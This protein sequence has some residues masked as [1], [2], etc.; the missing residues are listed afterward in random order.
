MA[1]L[2][3]P[4]QALL[5]GRGPR[6]GRDGG[7]G[8]GKPV[9]AHRE[10]CTM[11]VRP[12]WGAGFCIGLFGALCQVA[13][14]GSE[15]GWVALGALDWKARPSPPPRPLHS[16]AAML[17]PGAWSF[18]GDMAAPR[19][20]RLTTDRPN[21]CIPHAATTQQEPST[22]DEEEAE[23]RL[24]EDEDLFSLGCG[25]GVGPEEDG[26]YGGAVSSEESE[27]EEDSDADGP[28]GDADGEGEA[29][30][31]VSQQQRLRGA[32]SIGRRLQQ[33]RRRQKTY[34][35]P[36][37]RCGNPATVFQMQPGEGS[38]PLARVTLGQLEQLESAQASYRAANSAA[39][40]AARRQEPFVGG[41]GGG[42]YAASLVTAPLSTPFWALQPCYSYPPS[43]HQ[44]QH[45]QFQHQHLQFQHQQ[46][47]PSVT[48]YQPYQFQHQQQ[49]Y[50][51]QQQHHQQQQH[52]PFSSGPAYHPL[53]QQQ[54]QLQG[55]PLV[56]Q[57]AYTGREEAQA[58]AQED[59]DPVTFQELLGWDEAPP[60]GSLQAHAHAHAQAQTQAQQQF[61][62]IGG[63]SSGGGG[64]PFPIAAEEEAGL[65]PPPA[66]SALGG[67]RQ[68]QEQLLAADPEELRT[69]EEA[70]VGAARREEAR[71]RAAAAVTAMAGQGQ[72]PQAATAAAY[73]WQTQQGAKPPRPES[74]VAPG[75]VTAAVPVP[76][77]APVAEQLPPA[78]GPLGLE[79][80][81]VGPRYR[82][83]R[84]L[85][86]GSYGEVAEAWDTAGKR[87]VAVKRI[88]NAFENVTD[89]R[90]I[91]REMYILRQ[92]R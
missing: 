9:R 42:M 91:Y 30:S 38:S 50:H 19:S 27:D 4:L 51:H 1:T 32:A 66:A 36:R 76:A 55:G 3:S 77:P 20:N 60:R 44:Q 13:E 57:S 92:L 11:T 45:Q 83:V 74:A 67:G 46:Q 86:H 21:P 52:A 84:L 16:S 41:G 12:P 53:K 73:A 63:G 43:Q 17:D 39:V 78:Q 81:E 61:D 56:R 90:R 18:C 64:F 58:Q 65:L 70:A 89:A 8:P 31:W 54:Q 88:R 24:V 80:W 62:S 72:A 7:I 25:S 35:R 5:Q 48:V 6:G 69:A 85:G 79:A 22:E 40:A 29:G 59:D 10:C 34:Q 15:G 33:Q 49:Q 75:D 71:Q 2:T 47:Q 37:Q 82:M 23:T 87:R 26:T 14:V 28:L 68:R